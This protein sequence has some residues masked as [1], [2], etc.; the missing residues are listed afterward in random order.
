MP[1]AALDP[2]PDERRGLCAFDALDALYLVRMLSPLEDFDA[3]SKVWEVFTYFSSFGFD[4]PLCGLAGLMSA[5][6]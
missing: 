1:R 2:A 4:A 3:S 5:L 6:L